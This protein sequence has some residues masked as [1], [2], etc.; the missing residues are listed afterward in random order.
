LPSPEPEAPTVVS[1]RWQAFAAVLVACMLAAVPHT[2]AAQTAIPEPMERNIK[3]LIA[4]YPDFLERAEGNELVWKDGTRMP[5]DDG[6]GEKD[7]DTRLER[8]DLE[9]MFYAPYPL[10]RTGT[11]PAFQSDP[12]RVRFQPFY[13][14]MYG[15]C[16]KGEVTKHLVDVAWLPSKSKQRLKVTRI[17]GVADQLQAVSNELDK[18]PAKF[19]KYLKPS[20]GTYNCRVVAGTK[21]LSVHGFGAAID[22]ATKHTDYWRWTKPGADGRYAYKNSIPWEIV[23]IFEKHGFVWG[24]KWYH[25]DTMHFE[26]RPEILAAAKAAQP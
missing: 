21:R 19:T 15:D 17:N 14:K 11:P 26:Y 2:G 8:P 1:G 9:D 13:A 4:S 7:F 12:G 10:A 5:F 6:T 16:T 20:A 24:G 22:I 3:A 18:L 23:E 25:Y